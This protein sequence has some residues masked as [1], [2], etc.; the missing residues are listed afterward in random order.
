M[1]NKKRT[2]ILTLYPEKGTKKRIRK[3][4]H[5][6]ISGFAE[7]AILKELDIQEKLSTKKIE[8]V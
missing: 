1:I 5:K 2:E 8:K 6:S 4:T 7:R 3:I